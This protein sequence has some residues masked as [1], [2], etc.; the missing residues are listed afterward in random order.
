MTKLIV[1]G[2][3]CTHC[4]KR[5][6]SL[7]EDLDLNDVSLSYKTGVLSYSNDD[8][9]KEDIKL[10]LRNTEYTVHKATEKKWFV[11]FNYVLI[12]GLFIFLT[13][14]LYNKIGVIRFDGQLSLVSVLVFGFVTSLHCVGMCG[15]IAL[16]QTNFISPKKN[17]MNTALYNAGRILTYSMVGAILGFIGDKLSI[18]NE[19][20]SVMFFFIGTIMLLLGLNSLGLIKFRIKQIGFKVKA[21]DGKGPFIVGILNGFMPCGPLQTM[22][23]LAITTASPLYGFL[24]MLVFGLGTLPLLF[25][26]SNI[27]LLIKKSHQKHLRR[28]SALI[29]IVM[30]FMIFSQGFNTIGVTS[31]AVEDEQAFAEIQDGHQIVN[32]YV[33]PYYDIDSVKVKKDI[34]VKLMIHV[35]SVSGCTANIMVPKYDVNTDLTKGQVHELVFIPTESERLKITCWMSMINTYLDVVD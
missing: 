33:D 4:E 13:G 6:L 21:M 18:T 8:I 15:G 2:M 35:T 31:L 10:L 28:V 20:R 24:V 26:F 22:Q 16:S 29:V 19:F 1:N 30:A 3:T 5:V 25:I 34:P 9:S 7:L 12:I 11:Y 17:L 14:F 23:L 32:I 27:G